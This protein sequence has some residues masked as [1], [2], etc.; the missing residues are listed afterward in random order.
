[1]DSTYTFTQSMPVSV[2]ATIVAVAFLLLAGWIA[3]CVAWA[4]V[5]ERRAEARRPA[6]R[7][8]W[9][10][11]LPPDHPMCRTEFTREARLDGEPVAPRPKKKGKK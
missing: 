4:Y 1:M 9:P 5:E 2:T 3:W 10:P 8:A 11:Y 6:P 7:L